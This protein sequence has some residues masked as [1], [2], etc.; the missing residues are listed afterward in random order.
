[1]ETYTTT[2]NCREEADE[3]S[4]SGGEELDLG[5]GM[6]EVCSS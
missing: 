2:H 3:N 4:Y 6:T 1:M 5:H